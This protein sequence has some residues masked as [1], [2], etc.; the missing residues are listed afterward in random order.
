MTIKKCL[1]LLLCLM[2]IS[3]CSTIYG[4]STDYDEHFD[5]SKTKS[6]NWAEL[7][8][9]SD[10][11][12]ETMNM[13]KSA[14]NAGLEEKGMTISTSNPD[15]IIVPYTGVEQQEMENVEPGPDF[16]SS[17]Q[18]SVYYGA[19]SVFEYEQGKLTLDF[20]DKKT[21]QL[22]WRGIAKADVEKIDT[23][24]QKKQLIDKAVRK[25]LKD[26]PPS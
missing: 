22:V 14:V 26:F 12:S 9:E 19:P 21:N 16:R 15:L 2:F 4:V 6:Y 24:E 17:W 7:K 23:P 25:I 18:T 20:V 5:F 10:A 13:V 1:P 11:K 8:P 3:S